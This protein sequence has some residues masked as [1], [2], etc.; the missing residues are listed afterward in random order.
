MTVEKEEAEEPEEPE[1]PLTGI[2]LNKTETVLKEGNT[3]TLTVI[4]EPADTTDSKDVTW[5]SDN[6]AVATVTDGE[7]TAVSE[8]TANVT[9][10]VGNITATCRVT[11]KKEEPEKP[12]EPEEPRKPKEEKEPSALKQPNQ[13]SISQHTHYFSW[14]TVQEVNVEQDGIEELRCNCGKVQEKNIIPASQVYVKEIYQ[15]LKEVPQNGTLSIESGRRYTFSDNMIG[16]F[17]ERTD[18]VITIFFE[19]D[20]IMYKMIIPSGVDYK[21]LLEDEE[22]FYGYFYFAELLGIKIETM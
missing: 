17:K 10:K 15:S 16:K 2:S 1:R 19:Y 8:G 9:A 5:T 4:Y 21:K 13:L 11:V 22:Y 18:V 12:E 3:E 20:N 7:V 6:S 14:V